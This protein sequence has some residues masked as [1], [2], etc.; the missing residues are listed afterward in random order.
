MVQRNF[1]R[2]V[3]D[4]QETKEKCD[5]LRASKQVRCD[6]NEFLSSLC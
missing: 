6:E 4:L 2:V 5:E 1:E 3:Q